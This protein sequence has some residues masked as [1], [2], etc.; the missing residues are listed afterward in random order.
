MVLDAFSPQK[1]W[2]EPTGKNVIV[3]V[4]DLGVNGDHTELKGPTYFPE[5]ALPGR[6]YG[7]P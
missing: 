1:V 6:R 2:E 7:R 4:I 5:R 3:A